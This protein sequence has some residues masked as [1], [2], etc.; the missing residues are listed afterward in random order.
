MTYSDPRD[1]RRQTPQ[2][3]AYTN[4]PEFTDRS[5]SGAY[6]QSA[7][8]PADSGPPSSYPASGAYP[9]GQGS[10]QGGGYAAAPAARAPRR[11]PDLD[12]VMF[13]GGVVMTGVV[14]GLAA[15]LVS[16]IIG[17]ISRA[18]NATGNLGTWSPLDPGGEY[19]FALAGFLAALVGGALW[20]VLQLITPTPDSFY[21]WIV[22]LLI[23]AA[24]V[25]PLAADAD[26]WRGLTSGVIHVCIG[27]PVL[28]L[29]PTMGNR[30]KNRS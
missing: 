21:R 27:I 26:I 13:A 6:S 4:N 29:I 25:V 3:R 7:S 28:S 19:W 9:Q 30:S 14:T 8:Y 20:Y 11:G 24:F 16:W 10:A 5:G 22:G 17:L 12:P 2:T 1:P 18:A 15:W 23:I